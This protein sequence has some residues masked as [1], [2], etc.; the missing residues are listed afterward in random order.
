MDKAVWG[1]PLRW[2]F[3][4]WGVTVMTFDVALEQLKKAPSPRRAIVDS[5]LVLVDGVECRVDVFTV[6][7][8][9]LKKR[10]EKVS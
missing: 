5:G 1:E 7:F 9:S 8:E 6:D 3:F 2:G 4:R 10:F